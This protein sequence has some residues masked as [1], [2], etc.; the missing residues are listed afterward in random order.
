MFFQDH[1]WCHGRQDDLLLSVW[2]VIPSMICDGQYTVMV[3]M[4]CVFQ[5]D[6]FWTAELVLDSRNCYG[7]YDL[8]W[9]MG[10]VM[11]RATSFGQHSFWPP[12]Y[13]QTVSMSNCGQSISGVSA[14]FW[15]SSWA[16]NCA[17]LGHHDPFVKFLGNVTIQ[18]YARSNGVQI[19]LKHIYGITRILP[20][21]CAVYDILERLWVAA[22]HRGKPLSRTNLT[23]RCNL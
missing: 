2:L 11:A 17:H 21:G 1:E 6:L 20:R 16:M 7:Q 18:K 4:L 9:T 22:L 10:L 15:S 8:L 23:D 13:L 3:S 14:H 12:A 19:E 5:W